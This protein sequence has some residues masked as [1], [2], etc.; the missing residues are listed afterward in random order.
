MERVFGDYREKGD[1]EGNISKRIRRCNDHLSFLL[2]FRNILNEAFSYLML[3]YIAV[4]VLILCFEVYLLFQMQ[5]NWQTAYTSVTGT[6]IQITAKKY[7]C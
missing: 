5:N 2:R 4:V 7:L 3:A 1:K 6:T